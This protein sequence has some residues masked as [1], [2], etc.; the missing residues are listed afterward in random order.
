M[1][2]NVF[3]FSISHQPSILFRFRSFSSLFFAF[4][5]GISDFSGS[6]INNT[7]GQLWCSSSSTTLAGLSPYLVSSSGV[8]SNIFV[9]S[10]S[11]R[12]SKY[13]ISPSGSNTPTSSNSKNASS[14]DDLISTTSISSSAPNI[15]PIE[16]P[17][18]TSSSITFSFSTSSNIP[19]VESPNSTSSSIT[20]F[21]TNDLW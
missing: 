19:P 17:K 18:S 15:K 10:P 5:R 9:S 14:P 20:S 8:G 16:S 7:M 4:S 1:N 6:P 3:F 2:Y 11:S 21:F 12:A 13:A